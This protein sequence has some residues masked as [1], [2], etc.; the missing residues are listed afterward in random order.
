MSSDIKPAVIFWILGCFFVIWNLV[1]CASYLFDTIASGKQYANVY[2]EE[3]AALRD[4]YPAWAMAGYAIGVWGGLLA[5][6]LFLIRK[7]LA[8]TMFMISIIGALVSNAWTVTSPV[9]QEVAGDTRWI[10]PMVI[11]AIGLFE[12]WY[13]RKQVS[14]GILT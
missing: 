2:G 12:I 14:R 6:V 9:L 13:S 7:R 1:G 4:V 11:V 5:A 10:M 3:M 8:V